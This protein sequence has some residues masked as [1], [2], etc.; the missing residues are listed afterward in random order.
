MSITRRE[1]GEMWLQRGSGDEKMG[2][3]LPVVCNLRHKL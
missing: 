3:E 2:R 1:T